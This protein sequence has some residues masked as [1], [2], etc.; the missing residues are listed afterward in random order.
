MPIEIKV[1]KELGN[2]EPKF[3]G[4]FTTRQ[5]II[6]AAC[7]SAAVLMYKAAGNFLPKSMQWYACIPPG[8]V[9]LLFNS[10]FYG[11]RF[12]QF[13]KAIFVNVFLAPTNRR[14]RTENTM[15]AKL[16]RFNKDFDEAQ[17]KVLAEIG[18]ETPNRLKTLLRSG[19]KRST[20]SASQAKKSQKGVKEK[21]KA[22]NKPVSRTSGKQSLKNKNYKMSSKAIR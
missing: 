21:R 6:F 17:E 14:Y 8:A 22:Q 13:L 4:P 2:F 7:G 11:M 19:K 20:E 3:I 9:A 15:Q 12:E 10:P 16:N 5:A 18:E 1:T